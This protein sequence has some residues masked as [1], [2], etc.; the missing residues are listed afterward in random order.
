M[1]SYF[2][3]IKGALVEGKGNQWVMFH[4][5][6]HSIGFTVQKKPHMRDNYIMF[7]MTMGGR[8]LE[9]ND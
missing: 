5:K 7:H 3:A 2:K 6:L 4:E 1:N 8:S 9:N